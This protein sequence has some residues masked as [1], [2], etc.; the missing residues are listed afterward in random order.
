M[1][2]TLG[3]SNEFRQ[4]PAAKSW[5]GWSTPRVGRLNK[6]LA[7]TTQQHLSMYTDSLQLAT[8]W[9]SK[10]YL[11]TWKHWQSGF[12]LGL[13]LSWV[14]DTFLIQDEYIRIRLVFIYARTFLIGN[15]LV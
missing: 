8:I 12:Q 7:L 14:I 4:E 10:D 13:K 11:G 9:L 2:S 6:K 15:E 5:F 3:S 1:G